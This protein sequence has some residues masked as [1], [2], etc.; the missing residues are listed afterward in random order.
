MYPFV[1]AYVSV[2]PAALEEVRQPSSARSRFATQMVG[3]MP[4]EPAERRRLRIVGVTPCSL[5]MSG[6]RP[7]RSVLRRTQRLLL[8]ELQGMTLTPGNPITARD[9]RSWKVILTIDS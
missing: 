5:A 9:G 7:R 2:E 6:S 1:G 3:T 8:R 4:V